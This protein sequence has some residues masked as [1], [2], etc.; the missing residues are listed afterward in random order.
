MSTMRINTLTGLEQADAEEAAG[1]PLH[2]IEEDGGLKVRLYLALE[3]VLR[4]REQP[5]LTFTKHASTSTW[6]EALAYVYGSDDEPA[7]GAG[8]AEGGPAE[9]VEPESPFPAGAAGG[10]EAGAAPAEGPVLP[11]DGTVAG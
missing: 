6:A 2:R 9:G 3:W 7:E 8:D 11:G 5:G 1:I 4:R 10:A